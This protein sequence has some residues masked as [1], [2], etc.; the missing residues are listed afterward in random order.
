L[1][2]LDVLVAMD[3][4]LT[5][6]ELKT[7]YR[8]QFPVMR[9]YEQD[10]WYDRNGRIVFTNNNHGL[11]GIG[12]DRGIF[13]SELKN[14]NKRYEHETEDDT[15]PGGPRM[16]KITYEGSFDR[17]DRERDYEITWA[18]FEERIARRSAA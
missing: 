3:F 11:A 12:V 4:G 16:C 13:E 6:D 14:T 18:A 7:I 2:E 8:V 1:I 15:R 9:Q 17:C 5:L 10:T